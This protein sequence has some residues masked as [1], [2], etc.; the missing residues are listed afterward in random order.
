MSH[1]PRMTVIAYTHVI[2]E[3]NGLPATSAERQIERARVDRRRRLVDVESG[4]AARCGAWLGGFPANLGIEL[5][6]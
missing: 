1:S 4:G 6:P 3:L 5:L 2:R